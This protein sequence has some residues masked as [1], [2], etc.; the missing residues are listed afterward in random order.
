[1]KEILI[2]SGNDHK[3]EEISKIMEDFDIKFRNLKEFG[4]VPEVDENG[5][6]LV[7][8]SEKKAR[9]YFLFTGIPCIADDTGLFVEALNGEPGVYSA[10]YSGEGATYRSNCDLLLK[11]LAGISNRNAEFRS[12]I[13]YF[14]GN[15]IL[16][17]EGIV[18]GAIIETGRGKNGFG[19]DPLFIPTGLNKTFAELNEEEK[20]NISHRKRALEKFRKWWEKRKNNL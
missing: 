13:S 5:S 8:N 11:N 2:A 20:N 12:V 10:R 16:S 14:D 17:F 4:D 19:Y 18:N 9:E 1:M 15:E 7:E 3:V 6:T